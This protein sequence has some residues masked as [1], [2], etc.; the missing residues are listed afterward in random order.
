MVKAVPFVRQRKGSYYK[1]TTATLS[2]YISLSCAKKLPP[3]KTALFSSSLGPS[4]HSPI[5]I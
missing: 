1:G 5:V 2:V 4:N 3:A